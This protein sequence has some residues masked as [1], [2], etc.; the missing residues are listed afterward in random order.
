MVQVLEFREGYRGS[1]S[2]LFRGFAFTALMSLVLVGLDS[3][4]AMALVAACSLLTWALILGRGLQQFKKF[5]P[6]G[7]GN[8]G[9][10]GYAIFGVL[11][12][13]S[14]VKSD[15]IFGFGMWAF[16]HLWLHLIS[17]QSLHGMGVS[18]RILFVKRDVLEVDAS[19]R[20]S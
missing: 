13:L 12:V 11:G 7:K 4:Y 15:Y 20:L 18:Q 16:T 1:Q 3:V 17:W 14:F 8:Y 6:E 9:A 19:K 2:M 10:M 5:D